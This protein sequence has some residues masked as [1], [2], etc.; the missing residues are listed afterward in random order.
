MVRG[1][2]AM[3]SY[4]L[5]KIMDLIISLQVHIFRKPTD[6]QDELCTP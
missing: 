3:H 5:R 2:L 6:K 4:H 1:I